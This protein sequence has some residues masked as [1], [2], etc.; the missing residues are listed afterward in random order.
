MKIRKLLAVLYL[1][2]LTLPIAFTAAESVDL[3][4]ANISMDLRGIGSYNVEKETPLSLNHN[5]GC[6]IFSY[7]IFSSKIKFNNTTNQV[8]VD[9]H[10]MGDPQSLDVPIPQLNT[11]TGLEHCIEESGIMPAGSGIKKEKYLID[12]QKGLLVTINRTQN[13]PIYC[14]I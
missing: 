8:L 10:Q 9:V 7:E 13:M 6:Y 12:G 4:P 3:G 5:F 1:I 14:S 11:Q 2:G